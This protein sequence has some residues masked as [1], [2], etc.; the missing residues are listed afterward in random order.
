MVSVEIRDIHLAI[1]RYQ[2]YS[3]GYDGFKI[4]FS[5]DNDSKTV[6]LMFEQHLCASLVEFLKTAYEFYLCKIVIDD[7][8]FYQILDNL[9]YLMGEVKYAPNGLHNKIYTDSVNYFMVTKYPERPILSYTMIHE[10]LL[11]T[12]NLREMIKFR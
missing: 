3:D 11:L 12:S 10:Q 7:E 6:K 1:A 5:R 4:V 8:L 9:F 2:P